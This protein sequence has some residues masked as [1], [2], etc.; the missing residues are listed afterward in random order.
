MGTR[1]FQ[2]RNEKMLKST[3]SQMTKKLFCD[4]F[5]ADC[6][7]SLFYLLLDATVNKRST[8]FVFLKSTAFNHGTLTTTAENYAELNFKKICSPERRVHKKKKHKK[9]TAMGH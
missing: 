5:L 2:I 9:Q 8:F 3:C 4:I 7:E 1:F 6:F